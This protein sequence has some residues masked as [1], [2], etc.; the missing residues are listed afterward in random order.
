MSLLPDSEHF[1][2]GGLPSREGKT[3]GWLRRNEADCPAF[4]GPLLPGYEVTNTTLG[5]PF[6]GDM[7][8]VSQTTLELPETATLSLL[9]TGG[10]AVLRQKK[11]QA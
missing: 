2:D 4:P 5:V 6:T 8:V 3:H 11:K 7:T 1:K 10:L 9:A